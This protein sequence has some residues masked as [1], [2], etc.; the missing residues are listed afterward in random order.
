MKEYQFGSIGQYV[1]HKRAQRSKNI[2]VIIRL[3]AL[4]LFVIFVFSQRHCPKQAPETLMLHEVPPDP[5]PTGP[6][7]FGVRP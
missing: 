4:V 1:E 7:A 3:A 6:L 2:G 5:P